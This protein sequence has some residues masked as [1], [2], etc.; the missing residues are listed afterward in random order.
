[1]V[2]VSPDL[3]KQDNHITGI[4]QPLFFTFLPAHGFSNGMPVRIQKSMQTKMHCPGQSSA[5]QMSISDLLHEL[6]QI[7]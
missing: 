5:A 1:M 3:G 7:L 2:L 6:H 4:W